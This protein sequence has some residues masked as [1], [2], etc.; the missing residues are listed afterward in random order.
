MI[1]LKKTPTTAPRNIKKKFAEKETERLKEELFELQNKLHA[2]KQSS[3]LV[4]LQGMDASGKDGTIRH[5]FSCVNPM[6]CLVKS[7]KAPTEEEK[8]HDFLWRIHPHAPAKGIIQIFNR[9]HYED[10]LV[11]TVHKTL[12]KKVI[13]NR[14]RRINTFEENLIYNKTL[15]LKFYLHVSKDEQK[16]RLQKRLSDPAKKW[17]YDAND[18]KEAG[19]RDKYIETYESIFERCS[20]EIPW[21]I[22]PADDKWYRNYFVANE[23]VKALKSLK[24]KYP[25]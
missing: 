15:L 21:M 13:D 23:L 8:A 12:I 4:V 20:P 10:I 5:V 6:G 24:M 18:M 3:I 16:K 14:Y 1:E 17:K 19:N 7:F 11:P 22:V 2:T 25:G 9:S